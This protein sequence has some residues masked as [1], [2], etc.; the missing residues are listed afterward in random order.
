M[1]LSIRGIS[2][3]AEFGQPLC[4]SPCGRSAAC[5]SSG[6]GP[7]SQDGVLT[8]TSAQRFSHPGI[9]PDTKAASAQAEVNLKQCHYMRKAHAHSAMIQA[10]FKA[11]AETYKKLVGAPMLLTK[12]DVQARRPKRSG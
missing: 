3:W 7:S 11:G 1:R 4:S 6:W 10:A 2:L 9:S 12:R 5:S 8:K